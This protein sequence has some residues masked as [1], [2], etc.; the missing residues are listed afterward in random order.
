[1]QPTAQPHILGKRPCLA[2]QIH[3]DGLRYVFRPMRVAP[4]QPERR[5]LDQIHVTSHEF[6]K[7]GIRAGPGVF[8]EQL[9]TV[10]HVQSPVKARRSLKPNKKVIAKT[11]KQVAR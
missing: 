5:G 7:G 11:G 1:M 9:L 10:P 3:K 8:G 2:G 6:A 4:H